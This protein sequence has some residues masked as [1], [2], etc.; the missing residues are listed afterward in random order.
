[1]VFYWFVVLLSVV[2]VVTFIA[3]CLNAAYRLLVSAYCLCLFCFLLW[4]CGFMVI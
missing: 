4:V 3:L 2:V 1:M